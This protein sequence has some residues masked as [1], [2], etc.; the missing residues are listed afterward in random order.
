MK[1][2]ILLLLLF[3]TAIAGAAPKKP[4]WVKQRPIDNDY[5]I[6][7]AF[8]MKEGK[9]TD[10]MQ[11]T[12]ARALREL[13]SEIK[14]TISSNSL[15]HQVEN[16]TDFFHNYES[17]INS[18]VF[19]TLEGYEIETW[20]DKKEY[21]VMARLSKK[22]YLLRQ[23]MKLD[24]AKMNS[25]MYVDEARKLE[26][27]NQPYNALEAWLQG[28]LALRN[29]L[30]SDLTHRTVNGT[31]D[32]GVEIQRGIRDLLSKIT[33]QPSNDTYSVG[34]AGVANIDLVATIGYAG[35][36]GNMNPYGIPVKFS[37]LSG[38]GNL[39]ES[40]TSNYDGF[41]S[42]SISNLGTG[43]KRQ[44]VVMELD[45]APLYS[46]F[47]DNEPLWQIF[48]G[49]TPLPHA[50]VLIELEKT[51]AYLDINPIF[52]NNK[53]VCK[54]LS[55]DVKATLAQS[56]FKFTNNSETA[57]YGVK[58]VPS[59]S[60]NE[61]KTGVGYSVYIVYMD[62]EISITELD[63]GYELFSHHISGVRGFQP[64]SYEHAINAACKTLSQ[65][66]N[67][68]VIPAIEQLNL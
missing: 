43:I 14:V 49:K 29:V 3:I 37:F 40:A 8:S 17:K 7:I 44:Q 22:K 46:H 38:T 5:Y 23:Q 12:R 67:D 59:I 16:N 47:E 56:F 61:V 60:R 62:L 1:N 20:E 13:A 21:W 26:A 54:S 58:I 48:M 65:Q 36:T 66:F 33:I 27:N 50:T 4:S 51:V 55:K 19:Q 2:Y 35:P 57:Q 11:D 10:Y 6:G 34:R 45:V 15:L 64:G 41:V 9:A 63:T 18:S 30:E 53:E 28:A 39:K 32:L 42:T 25:S 52:F 68:E 31:V 24:Q